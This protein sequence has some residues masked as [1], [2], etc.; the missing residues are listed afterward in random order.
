MYL[1]AQPD[2]TAVKFTGFSQLGTEWWS[3]YQ[4]EKAVI[5]NATFLVPVYN[6]RELLHVEKHLMRCSVC[7]FLIYS[8]LKQ[9][10]AIHSSNPDRNMLPY[11]I[12]R[13]SYNSECRA[14][15]MH[16]TYMGRIYLSLSNLL[17]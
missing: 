2:S 6:S 15:H 3:K 10:L 7:C 8:V 13:F 16:G 5:G 12:S 4:G 11:R 1:V 14:H 17:S 9:K